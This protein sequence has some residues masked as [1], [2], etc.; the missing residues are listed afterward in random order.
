MNTRYG[1]LQMAVRR[2]PYSKSLCINIE[3]NNKKSG[4]LTT[5]N[6]K[7]KCL[8]V[9]DVLNKHMPLGNLGNYSLEGHS[10]VYKLWH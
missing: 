9:T 7:K 1:T 6:L 5:I 2:A 4:K 3:I 10:G 8:I